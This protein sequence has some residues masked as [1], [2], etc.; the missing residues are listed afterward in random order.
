MADHRLHAEPVERGAEHVVVVEAREQPVVQ[1]S[2]L[3]L[4]AVDDALVEIGGAKTPH[5]TGEVDV[6]RVVH[7]R[8][9]IH[10]A[11]QLRE[12][13][14]SLAAVVLDLEEALLD[15]DVRR[16]VLAHRAELHQVASGAR[17]RERQEHVQGAYHVVRLCE[18]RVL[19]VHHRVGA[20]ASRRSARPPRA[21]TSLKSCSTTD[22]SHRSASVTP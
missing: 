7:L 10:R 5:P 21:R 16:A 22:Q 20:T 4:D 3:R 14:V 2:L 12:R 13:Q 17:S 15:V 6:V 18:H 19:E 8:Q 11:G 9:V 1:A